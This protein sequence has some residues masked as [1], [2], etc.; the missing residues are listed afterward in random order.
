[1]HRTRTALLL[2]FVAALL[3]SSSGCATVSYWAS[4]G[5]V[6]ETKGHATWKDCLD[7]IGEPNPGG[8]PNLAGGLLFLALDFPLM[9]FEVEVL[10]LYVLLEGAIKIVKPD[11]DMRLTKSWLCWW[12]VLL[13]SRRFRVSGFGKRLG[14]GARGE[15]CGSPAGKDPG[16]PSFGS[17]GQWSIASEE[18]R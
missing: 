8:W 1:M 2:A 6:L 17:G 11:Y 4:G 7:D 13:G 3:L 5:G 12:A 18:N 15:A 14:S 9:I 10:A 16:L